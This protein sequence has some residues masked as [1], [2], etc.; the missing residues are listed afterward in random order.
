MTVASASSGRPGPRAPSSDPR[1]TRASQP[2]CSRR[3]RASSRWTHA[4]QH[5]VAVGLRDRR[6]ALTPGLPVRLPSSRCRCRTA[7]RPSGEL[8]ERPGRRHRLRERGCLHDAR[9]HIRR[10][11][12]VRRWIACRLEFKRTASNAAPATGE[13]HGAVLPRRGDRLRRGSPARARNA[14]ART[15]T[16]SPRCGAISTARPGPT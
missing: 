15:T 16:G 7:S 11:Y 1:A 6:G 9:G 2:R 13:V 5:D 3:G 10:R 12:Q 4:M 14:G 8:V